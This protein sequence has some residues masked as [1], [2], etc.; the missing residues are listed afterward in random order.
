MDGILNINKPL[1]MTSHDVVARVRKLL[2]QRRVG[3]AGTLDPAASGVLPI[4]V[5]QG[6]RVAEYLSESG[7]AYR[8]EIAFGTVTDT[9]DAEGEVTRSVDASPL[10]LEQ[11][12][13]VIPAFLGP[14]M[15]LPPRYS[16]IKLQGQAAYKLARAGA[17]VILQ[18]RPIEIYRLHILAWQPGPQPRLSLAIECSKGT[19][20]RSLAYDLGERLGYGAHLAALERTRSGTYSLTESITLEQ[21]AEAATNNTISTYLLPADSALKHH[22]AIQLDAITAARI[23]HGNPFHYDPQAHPQPSSELVRIYDATGCFIAIAVWDTEQKLWQPK[24]VF[25]STNPL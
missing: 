6:T 21:L 13:A 17:E 14:Q 8:A 15:Q 20:I 24:K 7:K 16:A 12:E 25:T 4:C 1:G 18:P 23:L 22:P 19:Y 5:G 2:K 11:I 10:T 9:Y 3:H